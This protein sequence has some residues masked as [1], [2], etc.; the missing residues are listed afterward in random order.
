MSGP[1][2]RV[3][4]GTSQM[5]RPACSWRWTNS[6][7]LFGEFEAERTDAEVVRE[8]LFGKNVQRPEIILAE[9]A[10]RY[11]ISPYR[12]VRRT[13]ERVTGAAHV[14]T[15]LLRRQIAD[16]AMEVALA[17]DL[18]PPASDLGDHL[19]LMFADP[20]QDEE[21]RFCADLIEKI[22]G[23]LR[24]P[25]HAAFEA[26]PVIGRDDPAHR[27]DMTVVFENNDHHM[28]ARRS[29]FECRQQ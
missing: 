19:G 11:T 5:L 27:P 18:V 6:E 16:R 15:E 1:S 3:E 22:E 7:R 23:K 9:S 10:S 28:L 24:V 4:S 21:C 13:F 29:L 20:S 12:N 2:F 14:I 17:G 25:V 8:P 26:V